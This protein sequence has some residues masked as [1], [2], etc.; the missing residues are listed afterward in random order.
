MAVGRGCIAHNTSSP[1]VE[2]T[3][4]G[5][6]LN[7]ISISICYER[8]LHIFIGLFSEHDIF[9]QSHMSFCD[10]AES[11]QYFAGMQTIQRKFWHFTFNSLKKWLFAQIAKS[12]FPRTWTR[13]NPSLSASPG[14]QTQLILWGLTFSSI[15]VAPLLISDTPYYL[16]PEQRKK[17]IVCNEHFLPPRKYTPLLQFWFWLWFRLTMGNALAY[18]VVKF[19]HLVVK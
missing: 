5:F 11:Q 15:F 3:Q 2:I 19:W 17:T 4:I 10:G 16:T 18:F 14:C 13:G 6:S 9:W 7:Y 1:F 8:Q 12:P